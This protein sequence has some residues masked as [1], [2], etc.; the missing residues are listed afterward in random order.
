MQMQKGQKQK[1]DT[2]DTIELSMSY[3]AGMNIDFSC[4]GV[5][6]NDKLVDE[7]YMIFYNQP[8]SPN[9][10]IRLTNTEKPTKF[11]VN[12][13]ALPQNASKLVVTAAIDSDASMNQL[14]TMEFSLTGSGETYLFNMSGSDFQKEKAIIIAEI[15]QK[16][17]VWRLSAVGQGFAGGLDALVIHYGGEVAAPT[18]APVTPVASSINLEKKLFL[19]KRISLEKNLETTAPKL[20]SLSKTAKISLEKKGLGEHRAKV[21]LC[22]D[23]SISMTQLYSSGV[24]QA[25]VEKILALGCRLDDDGM[26]DIFLFGADGYQPE[27]ISFKDFTGYV[28]RTIK[29]YPLEGDTKYGVAIEMVRKHYTNYKYE[30]SEPF[31]ANIPVYV[32]FLTDGQ[33]SDKAAATRALKNA[34]YEPIF[35]QFMGVGTANFSYLEKLDD[36]DGRYIDN[37]DFFSVA[38][39]TSKTDEQMYEALTNEYPGWLK[40]AVR[41][42]LVKE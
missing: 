13:N 29:K 9:K 30:R 14:G 11:S 12:L 38:S 24:V 37:A 3:Q 36:L 20:L 40:E 18:A 39:L 16:D 17:G 27:P 10:E 28:A 23:I 31:Q 34:S 22:L 1:I 42:G 4:F 26:I 35:W 41:K 8:E 19:E 2:Q 25:F 5:N 21:A 32:M 7:N 33:P 15:Y 6:Q